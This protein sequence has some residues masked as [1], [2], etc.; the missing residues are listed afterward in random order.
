M[1]TASNDN[2]FK[3]KIKNLIGNTWFYLVDDVNSFALESR[4]FGDISNDETGPKDR[5]EARRLITILR[6]NGIKCGVEL[7]DEWVVIDIP[8]TS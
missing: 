4:D 3:Q 7:V 1:N 8:K 6:A 2:S 5:Q